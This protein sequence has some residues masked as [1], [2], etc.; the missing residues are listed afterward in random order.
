MENPGFSH[1]IVFAL[2]GELDMSRTAELDALFAPALCGDPVNALVDFSDVTFMDSSALGWLL[3]VQDQIEQADGKLHLVAPAEGS[4]M[5][6]LS[7][8]G[9][10]DRFAV[11]ASRSAAEQSLS[12]PDEIDHLLASFTS[13]GTAAPLFRAVGDGDLWQRAT[14]AGYMEWTGLGHRLTDKGRART[15]RINQG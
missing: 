14:D 12:Q 6:L 4:L 7:L 5:R 10:T 15:N 1:W 9:L 3:K 2:S 8:S 11:F 13:P